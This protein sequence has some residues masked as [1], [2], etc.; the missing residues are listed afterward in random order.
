MTQSLSPFDEIAAAFPTFEDD[1]EAVLSLRQQALADAP[2]GC[3]MNV[4][5]RGEPEETIEPGQWRGAGF[6]DRRTGL[7]QNCPVTPLGTLGETFYFLN[8]LGEVHTLAPNAGKGHIDALFKGRPLYLCWAWPQWTMPRNKGESPMVK[9]WAAEEARQDLFAACAY[10]GAFELE[11]RVRGRGAWRDDNGGLIYHAGDAVMVGGKWKPPGEHGEYIY[12]GRPRIGRPSERYEKA[13]DGSP[14][15][16]LLQ[17]LQSWNW[18]R[19]EMDA[20]LAL[21]WLMTAMVGGGLEQRPV[22]YVVGTEGAGKSTL[23]KLLRWIMNGALLSTSNTTQAGIYQKV[24]QDSVAVMVDELEAKADTR[25]TDKILELA[26]IAYS[27]DKMQRGGKDGVGQEFSVMS[28]FLFSSIALPAM[29]AQDASRMA[30]LMMRERPPARAGE[31]GVDVLKELGLR[32]AKLAQAVGRQLLRRMF[33]WC[34][35]EGD[36]SRWDR[37][38][39]AMREMLIAAGHEDRS[40]DTFGALAA[41]CHVALSEAMPDAGELEHWAAWLRADQLNETATRTKTWRRCFDLMLK[42]QPDVWR[43][44]SKKSVWELLEAWQT[45]P[46]HIDDVEKYLPQVGLSISFAADDVVKDFSTARLFVPTVHPGLNALFA[47]S[48]WA[49]RLATPGPWAGVLRQ[50]PK[51]LFTNGGCDKGLDKKFKGM[52]IKLAEALEA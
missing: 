51:H 44:N 38:R 10:K 8:T 27:G 15:D 20:R 18:D 34:E 45:T 43:T 22:V 4:A 40:A 1:A 50:M 3:P 5:K 19:G 37:L 48:P 36:R 46:S 9:N 14:G 30:V 47:G 12:P 49:G 13:G 11:D 32:E 6:V 33:K 35:M 2:K 24:R 41:G 28:S 42:Q 16:L 25:T 26:R 21:G 52:F 39:D 31:R 17:A 7:P 23:Q 29:D